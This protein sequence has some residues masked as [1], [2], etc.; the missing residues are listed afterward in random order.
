MFKT[1][2]IPDRIIRS[3]TANIKAAIADM[4]N[5]IIVVIRT[6]LR[7]GQVIFD[8]SDLTC[9]I[10]WKGFVAAMLI[11]LTI[12]NDIRLL[13]KNYKYGDWLPAA[14]NKKPR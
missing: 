11:S 1:D 2:W 12:S 5:T 6:S 9:C 14:K 3:T 10:N 4:I 8:T 7:V 13:F